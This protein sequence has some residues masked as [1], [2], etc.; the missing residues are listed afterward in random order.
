MNWAQALPIVKAMKNR[1]YHRGIGR[2][3][4][5][6]M[7]G[8]KMKMGNDDGKIPTREERGLPAEEDETFSPLTVDADV[9]V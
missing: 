9:E 6:A 1:R 7:F 8:R 3:P 4:F 5:E 2:S